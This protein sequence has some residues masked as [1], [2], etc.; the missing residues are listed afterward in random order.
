MKKWREKAKENLL[1]HSHEKQHI[2]IATKEWEFTGLVIDHLSSDNLCQ[3]C[4]GE[5][6][7]YH[8][9]IINNKSKKTLNVG[10]SCIKKFDITV[11]DENSE[12]I[13]GK[14]RDTYLK[15][16]ITKL[17]K[18]KCIEVLR[19][20]WENANQ[21]EREN[22]E[23]YGNRYKTNGKL[24]PDSLIQ[25]FNIAEKYQI[26]IK[27][28]MFKVSLRSKYHMSS[29]LHEGDKNKEKILQCL[30]AQQRK[31]YEIKSAEYT[32]NQSK[33]KTDHET[34]IEYKYTLVASSRQIAHG[35][36][37]SIPQTQKN[38]EAKIPRK[39]NPIPEYVT[40]SICA[41]YTNKWA[42][43]NPNVCSECLKKKHKMG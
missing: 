33:L 16:L 41:K 7:R 26:N 35:S 25:I 3:L 19:S 21:E 29:L 12:E 22:I 2:D 43:Y 14:E 30:T 8:Y 4:E 10:S 13:Y 17:Q 18:K 36:Q 20:L 6:L 39:T 9:E 32:E 5:N 28:G 1:G 37:T 40:C 23:Y 24:S 15:K 31:K 38:T 42:T 34:Q 11:Y 27:Y